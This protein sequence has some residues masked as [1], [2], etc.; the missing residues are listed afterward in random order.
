MVSALRSFLRFLFRFEETK[1]DI[2]TAVPTV[3]AWR[4]YGPI[5]IAVKLH[6]NPSRELGSPM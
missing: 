3:A 6:K 1:H 5:F 4:L 2:S